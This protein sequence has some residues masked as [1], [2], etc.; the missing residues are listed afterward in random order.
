[1]TLVTD[2][3]RTVTDNTRRLRRRRHHRP[4]RREGPRR[5]RARRRRPRRLLRHR[6]SRPGP[7]PARRSSVPTLAF[8]RTLEIAGKAQESYDDLAERGEKLVKRLRTQK[9][10]Q[11]LIAQA[12]T[13]VRLG[14]GAV[15]TARKAAAETQRAARA[16]LT[17]GRHEAAAAVETVAES[18]QDEAATSAKAVRKSAAG[19]R[20]AGQAHDHHRPQA[21]RLH[22]ARHQGHG[23]QRPQDGR[24]PRARPPRPPPPR[25]ATDPRA[26]PSALRRSTR[27]AGRPPGRSAVGGPPVRAWLRSAVRLSP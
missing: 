10:T 7:S 20:T 14:K 13:T 4:R 18:V 6:R 11:D 21:R 27:T 16:T 17:T 2:I 19:T 5:P 8:N 23:H 24:R 9:A 26:G 12:E 22:P 15:T 25:S 1:M 3:R